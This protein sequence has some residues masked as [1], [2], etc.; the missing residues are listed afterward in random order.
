MAFG[1]QPKDQVVEPTIFTFSSKS[2]ISAEPQTKTYT[3][4]CDQN[5]EVK[6]SESWAT[7]VSCDSKG[8][9]KY[10]LTVDFSMNDGEEDRV[11]EITA[12]SGTQEKVL[13]VT[14]Q[15][16]LNSG[17]ISETSLVF[18]GVNDSKNLDIITLANDWTLE[19]TDTK[20]APSWITADLRSGS[21]GKTTVCFKTTE[22][23]VSMSDRNC[24]AKITIGNSYFYVTLTQKKSDAIIAD[25][26][27]KEI[28]YK[29]GVFT[30]TIGSNTD[31]TVMI[32]SDWIRR[33]ETKSGAF[34]VLDHQDLKFFAEENTDVAGRTGYITFL[35][36]RVEER[37]AIYQG[38]TDKIILAEESLLMQS[39]GGS[40]TIELKSNI[41]YSISVSGSDGWLTADLEA[42]KVDAIRVTAQ[43]NNTGAERTATVIV[44]G[45]ID[46]DVY[47]ELKITQKPVDP[48]SPFESGTYGIYGF[49]S[50]GENIE[51]DKFSEQLSYS[52][53]YFRL[54]SPSADK[55]IE[56]S[57]IPAGNLSAGQ[58]FTARII[59]NRMDGFGNNTLRR[60]EVYKVNGSTV[61]LTDANGVGY[62]I[63]H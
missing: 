54:V 56:I 1:C 18:E 14:Q 59:Q 22:D 19:I 50:K 61:W 46:K 60:V 41:E 36:G 25:S 16:L 55:F 27:K 35:N 57:G 11:C 31:F 58:T 3:I 23:N 4:T 21:K 30:I 28:D 44:R 9:N 5:V 15:S 34:D 51:Y 62:T 17:V 53:T 63:K 10:T 32:E 8:N 13:T 6:S 37:V 52:A 49:N 48:S 38:Y 2:Q 39:F 33:E 40:R 43:P 29:G 42:G 24:F 45:T 7:V 20:A 12:K 47:D 26:N